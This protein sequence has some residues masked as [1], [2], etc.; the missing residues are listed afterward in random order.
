M[1]NIY[2]I[3]H[4][5]HIYIKILVIFQ[6]ISFSQSQ[7]INNLIQL[8][9]KDTRYIHFSFNLNGDM[10][11]DATSFP[12]SKKRYFYALKQNS[13]FYFKRTDNSETPFYTMTMA[14]DKGK[15]EGES[16]LIKL[17]SSVINIHGKELIYGISKK[18]EYE[19]G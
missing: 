11:I 19:K 5:V 6:L 17:S 14:H 18:G 8:G 13:K 15:I 12:V 4:I 16:Y 1:K 2:K 9:E 3:K 7:Q 10:I